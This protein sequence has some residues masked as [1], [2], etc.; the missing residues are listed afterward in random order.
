MRVISYSGENDI[1]LLRSGAEFFPA[2]I[3]AIDEARV[4][5]YLETYIFSIDDTG[6]L[7]RDALTRAAG[8]GVIVSV[9]TD[10]VGTGRVASK[11]VKATLVE[12]GV[13]HRSFNPWFRR[14]VARS[15]RKLCVVDRKWGFVGGLNIIDDFLDDA[16]HATL[17]APRWDFAVRISGPLVEAIHEEMQNQWIRIGK[18]KLRAR[19]DKFKMARYTRHGTEPG[20]ALA[21]LVVRDNLRN[22]R[23]IQRAYLQALGRAR[24]TAF[25]ANP[26][27]APGRKL[28]RALEEAAMRGV[29][30]TLLLGVGQFYLQ[31]AVAHSFYPKLLRAGVRIVEY[32]KTQLHAKVAVIDDE[33]AT[34]G[35]SNYDGLSLF[36]NQEANVVVSDVDFAH[37]LRN[38]IEVG[39][40]EGR[41]VQLQDFEHSPWYKKLWYGTAFLCYRGIIHVITLGQDA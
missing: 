20:Q 31:D 1:T 7:V 21:G 33:W 28:R 29:K 17:P 32:T 39:L 24:E 18:M 2:L 3:A 23:T 38:E 34:V 8:R 26:Y 14:G 4:E 9:I 16:S 12:A 15:H 10:W 37:T 41:L 40:S 22:R 5:I 13:Q 6:I 25:L 27:F 36:V 19:W 35:S 30:V 11:Q